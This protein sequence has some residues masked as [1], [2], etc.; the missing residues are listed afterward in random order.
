MKP[1]P[2]W[3]VL[4]GFAFA[5]AIG[6]IVVGCA[7]FFTWP[8][9]GGV[10]FLLELWLIVPLT[11][12]TTIFGTMM[13]IIPS[14]LLAIV[15]IL[16]KLQRNWKGYIFTTAMG[17]IC[18]VLWTLLFFNQDIE[19]KST[20]A[21]LHHDRFPYFLLESMPKIFLLGAIS[22]FVMTCF[23]LPMKQS[24][25]DGQSKVDLE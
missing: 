24:G 13:Y 22:S 17:G 6:G 4:I 19:N 10:S 23:V 1:Y 16:F 15:Y 12:L 3:K 25:E 14:L 11:L 5:P 21:L 18:A 2:Y 20:L 7:V 8:P 9:I